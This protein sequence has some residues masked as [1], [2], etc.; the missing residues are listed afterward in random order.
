MI[1]FAARK[2]KVNFRRGGNF[3]LYE[4]AYTLVVSVLHEQQTHLLFNKIK[5]FRLG[6][7]LPSF[8]RRQIIIR[9]K[10]DYHSAAGRLSLLRAYGSG[11]FP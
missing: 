11:G 1:I 9:A 5:D 6:E 3:Q 10:R 4:N 7:N 8:C 2:I